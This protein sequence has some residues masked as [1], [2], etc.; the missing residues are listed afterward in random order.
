MASSSPPPVSPRRPVRVL[1]VDDERTICRALTLA[2]GRAGYDVRAT[3]SAE[4][5]QALLQQESFDCLVVDLHIPDMRGDVLFE[6]AAALRPCL[7]TRTIFTTGDLSDRADALIGAC[8]CP[9]LLKPFDLSELIATVGRLT[10]RVQDAS[11]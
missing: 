9:V 3:E 10:A 5:A 2:L 4:Q 1:V 8:N 6:V 7:R 11:A